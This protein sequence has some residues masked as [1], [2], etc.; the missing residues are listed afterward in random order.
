MAVEVH[1]P[2]SV[3]NIVDCTGHITCGH[4]KDAKFVAEN[5][6]DPMN[7]LYPENKIVDLDTFDGVS[8]WRK[9][10]K[11]WRLSIICCNVF[12]DQSIPFIIC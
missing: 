7:D 1:L 3:Q 12:L 2:A 11:H 6:F 5:L 4:K 8:V 10:K 9:A